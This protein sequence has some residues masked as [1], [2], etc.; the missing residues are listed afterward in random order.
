MH[1]SRCANCIVASK[2]FGNTE[3]VKS[4]TEIGGEKDFRERKQ[5][6]V[7][8]LEKIKIMV[9]VAKKISKVSSL[10]DF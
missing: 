1:R 6:H 5:L 8:Q 2:C 7:Q 9:D 4:K 10:K 3:Y